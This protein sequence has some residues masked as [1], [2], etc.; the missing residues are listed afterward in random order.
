MDASTDLPGGRTNPDVDRIDFIPATPRSSFS[1]IQRS[2]TNTRGMDTETKSTT[3]D[4]AKTAQSGIR[5]SAT[6][7]HMHGCV[8]SPN[9][10]S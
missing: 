7:M 4:V 5:L 1:G 2:H 9:A 3:N 10:W 8:L 6:D